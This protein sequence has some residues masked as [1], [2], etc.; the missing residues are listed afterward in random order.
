MKIVKWTKIWHGCANYG[1][2]YST[3]CGKNYKNKPVEFRNIIRKDSM[4]D[5]VLCQRCFD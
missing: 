5:E 3:V 2:P 4:K 1:T